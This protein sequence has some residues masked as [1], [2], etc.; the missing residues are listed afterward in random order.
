MHL[1]IAQAGAQLVDDGHRAVVD[2]ETGV[3]RGRGIDVVE[4]ARPGIVK[5]APH[6]LNQAPDGEGRLALPFGDGDERARETLQR[7]EQ[8][9]PRLAR[10]LLEGEDLDVV[11]VEAQVVAMTLERRVAQEIVEERVMR[12]ANPSA[13]TE[14]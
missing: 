7:P 1:E 2:E 14:P 10:Q 11:V 6:R 12:Q 4:E 5:M 8:V 9:R 13:F 3:R